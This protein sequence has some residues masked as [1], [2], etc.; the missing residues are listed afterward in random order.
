MFVKLNQGKINKNIYFLPSLLCRMNNKPKNKN[1]TGCV[2][3]SSRLGNVKTRLSRHFL[4]SMSKKK[5]IIKEHWKSEDKFWGLFFFPL[6]CEHI[7][8]SVIVNPDK[9]HF[10]QDMCHSVTATLKL[11][12][13]P[14]SFHSSCNCKNV[15]RLSYK[16]IIP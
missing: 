8:S 2:T 5:C 6:T 10:H 9:R 12:Q 13:C 7:S 11:L 14:D 16:I 15:I 3:D 4:A 1:S